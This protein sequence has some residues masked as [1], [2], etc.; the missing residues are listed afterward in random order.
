MTGTVARMGRRAWWVTAALPLLA[1]RPDTVS[2]RFDP[3]IGDTY[4]FRYE[5]EIE[6]TRTVDGGEPETTETTT[7]ITSE[8]EVVDLTDE[9]TV[10]AVALTD[11]GKRSTAVVVLDRTGSVQAVQQVAGRSAGA[12][13]L[14]APV[15]VLAAAAGPPDRP[16]GLGDEWSIGDGAERGGGRLERLGIVDGHKVATASADVTEALST[17][18]TVDGSEVAM[19][20]DLRT[21]STTTFDLADGAVRRGTLRSSGTVELRI[22]PP[23]G[24]TAEPVEATITYVLRVRTTRLG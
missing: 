15:D 20:G 23:G 9:G 22:A 6:V 4:R 2:L 17:T 12:L 5:V 8:Q 14:P 7:T 3:A 11:D 16:L 21:T 1:C 18:R 19:D 13:G 24:V 10:V